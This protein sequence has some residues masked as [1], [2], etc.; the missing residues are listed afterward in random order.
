MLTLARKFAESFLPQEAIGLPEQEQGSLD[1]YPCHLRWVQCDPDHAEKDC[2]DEIL[3]LM[4]QTGRNGL[5]NA[6]ITLLAGDMKSGAGIV[7]RLS[8]NTSRAGATSG[9]KGVARAGKGSPQL[10]AG[11]RSM[12]MKPKRG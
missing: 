12:C 1:L 3:S 8:A 10:R 5:A 4:R 7:T 9:T 11:P 6:D 2:S